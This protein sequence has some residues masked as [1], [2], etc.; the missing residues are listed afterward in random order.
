[1]EDGRIA[2]MGR[3]VRDGGGFVLHGDSG[4]RWQLDLARMPVDHVEKRVK[5]VG[6]AVAPD[7]IDVDAIGP[8]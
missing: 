6:R 3:L 5:V 7:W 8:A 2:E 4:C 1:M